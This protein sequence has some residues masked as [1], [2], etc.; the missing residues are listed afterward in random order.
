M[1]GLDLPIKKFNIIN[2]LEGSPIKN[3]VMIP[4]TPPTTLFMPRVYYL[5][6]AESGIGAMN[7]EVF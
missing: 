3:N 6:F 2:V 4:N 1:A 5:H 7:K